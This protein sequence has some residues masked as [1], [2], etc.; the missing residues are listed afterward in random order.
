MT[1]ARTLQSPETVICDSL[2]HRTALGGLAM[3][4]AA[5]YD[6]SSHRTALGG[7]AMPFAAV[8]DSSSHPTGLRTWTPRV[9][10]VMSVQS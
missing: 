5:V 4:F 6:S 8:Y 9:L 1:G 3:P 2:S 7:L 10:G